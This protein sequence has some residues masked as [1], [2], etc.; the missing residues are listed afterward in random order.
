MVNSSRS[1]VVTHVSK[2]M[3]LALSIPAFAIANQSTPAV[4]PHP[5]KPISAVGD[6]SGQI[7]HLIEPQARVSLLSGVIL[8]QRGQRVVFQRAYGLASWELN[9]ANNEHT[10]FGI[11]SIAKPMTEAIVALLVAQ[12]R[13]QPSDPVEKYIPGFPRGPK[14]GT[15]TI[16]Q[17]LKHTAGVP[18]RVTTEVEETQPWDA[19]AIV[20]RVKARGLMFEPGSQA[21]YSSA[22]YT[23]LAR[24]IEIVEGR[25]FEDVLAEKIS[26]PAQM[27]AATSETGLRL[28]PNRALPYILGAGS[29]G[30]AVERAPYAD[31]RFL[32]GAGSVYAT[33]ADL[34][35]FARKARE[36]S[37]GE[38]L[39]SFA[40]QGDPQEWRG[41]YGRFNG[42]EASVDLL[43]SQ[44]VTFAMVSNLQSATNWQLRKRIHDLLLGRPVSAIPL[45]P[46]RVANF[47]PPS[48]VVGIYGEGDDAI[49]IFVRDGELYRDETQV[50]PIAGDRYY[51][52]PSAFTM[53]FHRQDGHVDS[54]VTTYA[55]GSEKTRQKHASAPIH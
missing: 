10:R 50:Y 38:E 40:S 6:V 31:L 36:G 7:D 5:E 15:P 23:C 30:P 51:L 42:Y 12:H 21:S 25:S 39:K 41:W 20:E 44:D 54:L 8:I 45:P 27:T 18:H 43:P 29:H 49:E 4:K 19:A 34:T 46:P 55:D 47:E 13:L 32:T 26:R 2:A 3:A 24:V 11:G 37:F 16:E 28:M 22:G 33:P 35:A 48:D 52:P 53:R 1:L 17:L 14:G 9:V